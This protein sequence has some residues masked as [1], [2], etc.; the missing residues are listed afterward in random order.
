MTEVEKIERIKDIYQSFLTEL[1]LLKKQA[2]D[3]TK[4]KIKAIEQQK[5][6]EILEKI[7]KDF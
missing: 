7:H 2:N 6:E 1:S 3:R 5:I 4:D